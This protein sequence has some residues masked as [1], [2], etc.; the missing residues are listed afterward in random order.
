MRLKLLLL[1]LLAAFVAFAA[2]EVWLPVQPEGVVEVHI[3]A[4]V[5]GR[6]IGR[7][8]KDTG[9]IRS[10]L[11]FRI[12]SKISGK[13]AR[14]QSGY[15]R[16]E[17][18]ASL[19]QVLERMNNGDAIFYRVTVPEGLRTDEVLALLA[20]ETGT[21][22]SVWNSA[23]RKLLGDAGVEGRLLPETY[24]Y[25]K[26]V[27]PEIIL[28]DMIKAQKLF[29]KTVSPD[30]LD[31]KNLRIVA[32]IV[33]K[34]TAKDEERPWVAAVIRNRLDK[35]MALQMDPTVIYG[36]WKEDGMF[37]GNLHR[38]D[39]KRD[40]P[41]NTY[42]RKGLPPTPICNPGKASLLAAAHPAQVDYLYFVAD[43]TGGHAFASDLKQH[44]ENVRRWLKIERNR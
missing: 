42:T 21:K 10:A 6:E 31:I 26:P 29:M 24:T 43:G 35:H 18:A 27:R 39:M 2:V 1:L 34:E 22:I 11:A 41:W 5:S 37:S 7:R 15:Y 3:P 9:V 20:K 19:W 13:A 8:L 28:A 32:S 44:A 17:S 23:L 38:V 40:T 36:L 16:F 25:R 4:G 30:W 14:L 12:L 33:E